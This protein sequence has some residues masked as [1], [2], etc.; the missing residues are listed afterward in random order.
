LAL[1]ALVARLVVDP[2]IGDAAPY[3][4]FILAVLFAAVRLGTG[5]AVLTTVLSA[6]VA[7]GLFVPPR[8]AWVLT[9]ERITYAIAFCAISA[10]AV[11][12]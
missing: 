4:L 5:P 9:Q 3:T 7:T 10:G 8:D 11:L 1:A 12:F 2:L 6:I